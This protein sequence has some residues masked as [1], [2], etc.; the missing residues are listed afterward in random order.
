MDGEALLL[1]H[2]PSLPLSPSLESRSIPCTTGQ[3]SQTYRAK[4]KHFIISNS[5]FIF[6]FI[7]STSFIESRHHRYSRFALVV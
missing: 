2:L 6:F 1:L 5:T 4:T 3:A 7:P